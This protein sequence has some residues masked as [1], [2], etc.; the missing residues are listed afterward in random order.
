MGHLVPL[1]IVFIGFKAPWPVL[2]RSDSATACGSLEINEIADFRKLQN[3]THVV[4]HVRL[5]NVDLTAAAG[6]GN[7]G[8]ESLA[9]NVSE[10]SDYLMVYRCTGLLTLQSI[11]PRLRIIRGQAQLFDKYALV[12]YENRNLRELGLVELLR[13]QKGFI[14]IESN[15]MLC[16]VGTI[17]WLYLL[18]NATQQQYSVKHNRP[19]S[20]CP[21]CGGPFA[22]FEYL[23]NGSEHCWNLNSPQLRPQ[24]PRSKDC[25]VACGLSG[26]DV[27]GKCCD[28]NCVTGCYSK[29]CELCANYQGKLGC[30]NQCIATYE[31]DR[32]KCIGNRE[33]RDLGRIPLARGYQCVK[34]CP[35]NQKKVVDDKG[36]IQC[37][38]ECKGDFHV[39]S[40]ADLEVLQD[41][42][43][44]NGSLIIELTNIKEKIVEALENALVS[45]KEITGYL[46][47][48]HSVQL[49]SLTFLQNLD[50]IRGEKLVENKYALFVVNNYHLEHIWPTNHQVIIQRGMLFFHLNPRLCYDKIHQLQSSLKSG[51]NISVADVSP[52][53]NGER[54]IC[55]D[56]VRSLRPT[57]ED[58]NSTAVR[59]ILT[60]MDWEGMET[61]LGYSFYYKEAPQQNVTMYDGRH[62][63]G[64]DNWLMDVTP[65]KSRRHVISGL[66]PYTQYAYFVKTLTRTDYHMQMDAYSKIGYFQTLPDRPSPVVRIHGSSD[67]SSQIVL[68]WWPPIRPNGVI[69]NYFVTYE[70]QNVTKEMKDKNYLS[71]VSSIINDLDCECVDVLPYYSGPQPDDEDYYNKDQI[72]YE[73]ALPN[74]IYVSK[75]HDYRRKEFEKVVDYQHLLSI[76]KKPEPT[77][78]APPT[79]APTNE[80]LAKEKKAA[81]N[82]ERYR[83]NSEQRQRNMQDVDQEKYKIRHPMTKCSNPHATVVQQ[84]EDKCVV[85]EKM[86]GTQLPGNQHYYNLS[87][88]EPDTF[89]RVT[90]RAC[91][92]GVV[93]GCSTPADTLLK[94][95]S[96]R[97]ERFI[98]GV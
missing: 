26:C 11:F 28:H 46:K 7:Y 93:N 27:A 56:G 55:G 95:A 98:Q 24:P 62:G 35:G 85:E 29:N 80:M 53:S 17:D 75:H 5:A 9:S 73:D 20:Q 71:A 72:T 88:L 12:V 34:K 87:Q 66:K 32:R 91:V 92:E 43:T 41:C 36:L 76:K 81:E 10:I 14:R 4:G 23:K 89:Y 96:L 60:Y 83:I 94:T 1:L 69:K 40:A 39:K 77:T 38:V 79:P 8:F 25:P 15:P 47:V 33:C 31:I 59:I 13:V 21:L 58:S 18:G 78:P 16:F 3:C 74:L 90:V 84:V 6:A 70:K 42:I 48:I 51:E 68:H 50:S 67:S 19:H 64:H 45:V 22:G 97:M 44:I 49:V 63:C 57:V 52:N 65:S 37:Q 30:V 86:T 61:L 54:V 2:A 82:Y